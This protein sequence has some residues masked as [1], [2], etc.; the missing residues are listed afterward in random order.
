MLAEAGVLADWLRVRRTPLPEM[1]AGNGRPVMVIPGF[2][3]SDVRTAALRR[4]LTAAGYDAHGWG[5]GRNLGVTPHLLDALEDR[6][7]TAGD[8]RP[9]AL[10]GWSLGGLYARELAARTP[11]LVERV[12]TMGS[13]F[14]GDP[15]GNNAW[16]L[17]ESVAGHPVDAPPIPRHGAPKPPVPTIALWSRR[18]GI[19]APACARGDEAESDRRIEVDCLHMGF[20]VSPAAIRAVLA[21]L[22]A[23]IESTH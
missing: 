9:V 12:V 2:L 21:A 17:Y 6:I 11:D 19:V 13:P 10:V 5:L 7:R 1:V 4:A 22:D 15:R 20:I 3:T 23:R 8:G 14:S 18:D 16:R